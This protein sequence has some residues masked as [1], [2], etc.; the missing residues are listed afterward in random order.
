MRYLYLLFVLLANVGFQA[1]ANQAVFLETIRCSINDKGPDSN[2]PT[3]I[4][5]YFSKFAAALN[6]SQDGLIVEEFIDTNEPELVVHAAL[7]A[8]FK[9]GSEYRNIT[10]VQSADV[11]SLI[12]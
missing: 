7:P 11:P 4:E 2:T 3:S 5:I 9:I 6:S 8:T 1:S 10:I 12:N